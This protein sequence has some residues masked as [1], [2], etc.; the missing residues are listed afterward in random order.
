[1]PGSSVR[2]LEFWMRATQLAITVAGSLLIAAYVVWR[3]DTG[4]QRML[5]ALDNRLDA[6]IT[7]QTSRIAALEAAMADHRSDNV[8]Q[9]T[10][11]ETLRPQ[12][13]QALRSAVQDIRTNMIDDIRRALIEFHRADGDTPAQQMQMQMDDVCVPPKIN[14]DP[15]AQEQPC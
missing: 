6:V 1:M 5:M 4:E 9:E 11:V 15:S 2:G 12:E 8:R 7:E 14:A 10:L 3:I 13:I